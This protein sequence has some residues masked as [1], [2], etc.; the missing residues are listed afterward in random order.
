MCEMSDLMKRIE[1]SL[2]ED[3]EGNLADRV[4][5]ASTLQYSKIIGGHH[6]ARASWECLKLYRDGFWLGTIM[7]CQSVV[8]A[9]IKFVAKRSKKRFKGKFEDIV[10]EIKETEVISENAKEAALMVWRHRDDFHHLNPAVNGIELKVKA[11]ECITG[12]CR[13]EDEIFGGRIEDGRLVP[14]QPKYYDIGP[15]GHAPVFLRQFDV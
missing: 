5:R 14:D 13:L 12:L 11:L 8:E 9:L 6:F 1:Q 3:F 4:E 2:R 7:G 15:E 10:R